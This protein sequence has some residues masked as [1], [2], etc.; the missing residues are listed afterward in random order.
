[1]NRQQGRTTLGDGRHDLDFFLS[2]WRI[3]NRKLADPLAEGAGV[4]EVAGVRGDGEGCADRWTRQPQH[5]L[6]ARFPRMPRIPWFRVTPVRPQ[7]R[8]L[9]DLV[10]LN[11]RAGPP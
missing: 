11:D 9:A 8:A 6:G 4:Q 3:V 2:E 7:E 1:M 10:G 5:L